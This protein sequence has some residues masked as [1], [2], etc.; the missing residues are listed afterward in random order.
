MSGVCVVSLCPCGCVLGAG[1]SSEPCALILPDGV[2]QLR[3]LPPLLLVLA[4]AQGPWLC[5]VFWL[6]VLERE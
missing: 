6:S 3:A 1:G 5:S 4:C 2:S